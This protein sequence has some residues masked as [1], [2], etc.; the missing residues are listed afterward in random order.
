[1]KA[2][3]VGARIAKAR[4]FLGLTQAAVAQKMSLARTTQVAIEQGRRPASVSELYRYA[5]VLNRPLDYFL[6]VGVWANGDFQ[7]YFRRMASELEERGGGNREVETRTLLEFE[8]LCRNYRELG[9]LSGLPGAVLPHFPEPR[10]FSVLE[11]ERTAATVRAHLDIGPDVPIMDLRGRLEESF[12]LSA[13]VMKME[14]RLSAAG[15][16]D[17]RMGAC[18]VMTERSVLRMRFTLA[19]AL[20]TLLAS[21]DEP[22]VDIH[23]GNRKTPAETFATSFAAALLVPSQ[24]LRERFS[25]VHREAGELNEIAILFLAR[26][27][28]VSLKTLRGRI[29][30][31][32]LASRAQLKKLDASIREV[33]AGGAEPIL[34]A[35]PRWDPLPER[36]VF[37]AMRASRKGTIDRTRLASLLGTTEEGSG[38]K[39]L[40]YLASVRDSAAD[41]GAEPERVIR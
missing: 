41:D 19:H 13:F 36:Y 1:M 29:E 30:S 21:R 18:V 15:F 34:G 33:S 7:P 35:E 37:L 22:F 27:Y 31:L 26:T 28:G 24:S 25:A 23:E 10:H 8:T 11:A 5:E 6:G 39:L 9:E 3:E 20:G 40:Q 16:F 14:S 2:E 38:L 32:K 4:E 17:P 12:G